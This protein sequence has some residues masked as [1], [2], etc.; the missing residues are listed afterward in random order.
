MEQPNFYSILPADVRYNPNLTANEKILYSEI[1]ALT[2]STGECWAGNEY[3]AR[4]Y[5]LS[6]RSITRMIKNLKDNG[7]IEIELV[8]RDN[9]KEIEKRIIRL[10][11]I[12]KN[13]VGYRHLCQGGIDKNVLENNT[14]NNIKNE[15]INNTP[16][17]KEEKHKYGTYQHVF[18]TNEQYE[19]LK[20]DYPYEYEKMIQELDEGLEL[21]NYSYKNHYLAI[22]KWH[23]KSQAQAKNNTSYKKQGFNEDYVNER[24]KRM[25][26]RYAKLEQQEQEKKVDVN[27]QAKM[28]DI[29]KNL[30]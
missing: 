7:L 30:F 13:V 16:P 10:R 2:V 5:N 17:P 15:Y 19:K 4:L 8:R 23:K 22:L 20:Q 21:H 11:G 24:N 1:T 26:E 18:L 25:L 3:F 29:T 28:R 12:D 9:C 14:S 6:T 27:A